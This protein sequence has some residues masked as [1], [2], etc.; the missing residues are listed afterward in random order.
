MV[1]RAFAR[2]IRNEQTSIGNFHMA[3]QDRQINCDNY[4]WVA[5]HLNRGHHEIEND[6]RVWEQISSLIDSKLLEGT[7]PL[8]ASLPTS[9]PS[10]K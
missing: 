6:P 9:P 3:Y 4:P 7:F 10:L 8:E 2:L 5:R 1:G